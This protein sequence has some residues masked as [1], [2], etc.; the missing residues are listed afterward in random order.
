[1]ADTK[2]LTA[3]LGGAAAGLL[4]AKFLLKSSAPASFI[5]Y[6][7]AAKSTLGDSVI[8]PAE[9]K[10]FIANKKPV[11]VDV[12]DGSDKDGAIDGAVSV[13]L[14]E[15]FFRADQDFTIGEDVK[16][17]GKVII[18]AGTKFIHD[19]LAGAKS[20]PILVSCG[21]GGQALI[22]G[23]LLSDYGYTNVKVVDGGNIAW[24]NSGGK[25]GQSA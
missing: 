23:K 20:K 17:E 13:S 24:A 10:Q 1:M 21:L 11:I 14:A 3:F 8:S 25:C 12:R 6:V 4:A 9:A 18:P 2:T 19:E 15:L 22:A 7:V 16:K 5:D